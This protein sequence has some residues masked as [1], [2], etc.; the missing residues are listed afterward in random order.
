MML[1]DEAIRKSAFMGVLCVPV[2]GLAGL[3]VAQFAVGDGYFV[4]VIAAPV[5]AFL[6][7][8]LSWW[9]FVVRPRRSS[10]FRG[11]LAGSFA[12]VLGHLLCW[13]ILLVGAYVWHSLSG[14]AVAVGSA[15]MNPME[16][17]TA[18]GIYGA[19]SLLLIGWVTVPAGA[20][21]GVLLSFMKKRSA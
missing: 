18:A 16:A 21:L 6:S 14:E 3:W 10:W 17:I 1:F 12:A 19:F 2:G 15:P 20:M 11:A 5:A 13:Y 4:F 8:T 7:G 9:L